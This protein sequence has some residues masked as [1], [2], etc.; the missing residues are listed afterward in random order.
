MNPLRSCPAALLA[1]TACLCLL[2]ACGGDDS[3]APSDSADVTQNAVATS[4]AGEDAQEES[5]QPSPEQTGPYD[6]S[7]AMDVTNV[8]FTA[9][10]ALSNESIPYGFSNANRDELNRPAGLD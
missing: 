3:P 9:L 2:S 7:V 8:D 5:P 1:L 6:A 4:S 10:S